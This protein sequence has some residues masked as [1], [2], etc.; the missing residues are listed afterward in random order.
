M[1]AVFRFLD[2][3][4]ATCTKLSYPENGGS[5]FLRNIRKNK[6]NAGRK[7]PTDDHRLSGNFATHYGVAAKK[8]KGKVPV[9][10]MK[11]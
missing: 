11:T 9:N 6:Y 4:E 5:A 2:R 3:A 10:A 1:R 8:K 7:N